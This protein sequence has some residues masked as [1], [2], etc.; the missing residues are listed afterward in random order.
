MNKLLAALALVVMLVAPARAT[1]YC[2]D[3]AGSDA[4]TGIAPSC[5]QTS[6]H[7]CSQTFAAGD[8]L[9]FAQG[10]TFR[11]LAGVIP[12]DL[13]SGGSSGSP[14]TLTSF[15]GS[16][17][18][19]A[20]P[21]I[22][23]AV[24]EGQAT[25]DCAGATAVTSWAAC[26]ATHCPQA[27]GTIYF[28]PF[29]A[30]IQSVI[31]DN[32]TGWPDNG[33]VIGTDNPRLA[34]SWT[35]CGSTSPA[36]LPTY[37][38]SHTYA[39]NSCI[40]VQAYPAGYW[41]TTA[42]GTTGAS[43]PTWC[44]SG[45]LAAGGKGT[46]TTVTDSGGVVWTYQGDSYS[47]NSALTATGQAQ[48]WQ[49]GT[50]LYLKLNPADS[51]NNHVIEVNTNFYALRSGN[52]NTQY[53]TINGLEFRHG[54]GGVLFFNTSAS[55]CPNHLIFEN[56]IIT[57]TGCSNIDAGQ[58]LNG[59]RIS[60]S[61]TSCTTAT[62]TQNQLLNNVVSY[63]GDHGGSFTIQI[64]GGDTIS[65]N[66]LSNDNHAALNLVGGCPSSTSCPVLSTDTITGNIV[67]D[68]VPSQN[69]T[70]VTGGFWANNLD[71]STIANNYFYN[72]GMS[73]GAATGPA[74][75]LNNGSANDIIANNT[76]VNVS[77]FYSTDVTTAGNVSA[78]TI[79]NN[80][81]S[82]S[83]NNTALG[84]AS[85]SELTGGTV[86]YNLYHSTGTNNIVDDNGTNYTFSAWQTAGHDTHGFS[87]NPLFFGGVAYPFYLGPGSVGINAAL[88]SLGNG[89]NMGANQTIVGGFI[90]P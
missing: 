13:V 65:G 18:A 4:N 43:A 39:A 73:G 85:T 70:S 57:Q 47:V 63:T 16:S 77:L 78:L 25:G 68:S 59:L 38:T 67:H 31:V 14:L 87:A 54:A 45:C 34:C 17:G 49:D 1:T 74:I 86:D 2:V 60:G 51:P 75:N 61:D 29:T 79:E 76:A 48:W 28:L 83:A 11:S 15:V 58:F 41:C 33:G 69:G 82:M 5:W 24:C 10:Q 35:S 30:N 88:T 44:T 3:A 9:E 22:D 56:N 66:N 37:Q 53:I 46:A 36:T 42:G 19:G 20:K 55:V 27:S 81:I 26:D 8:T 90:F 84:F 7:A 80:L 21:I 64:S 89:H 6:A 62:S 40:Q 52:T 71:N 23:G 12:C 72:I 32:A 50:N